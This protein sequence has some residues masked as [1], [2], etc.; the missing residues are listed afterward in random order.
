MVTEAETAALSNAHVVEMLEECPYPQVS[1]DLRWR[2]S[3][4]PRTS[5]LWLSESLTLSRA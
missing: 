3:G 4:C 1:W 2:S 5:W